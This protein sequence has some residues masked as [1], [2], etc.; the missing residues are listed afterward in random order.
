MRIYLSDKVFSGE[1]AFVYVKYETTS[2]GRALSWLDINQ[3]DSKV[4]PYMNSEC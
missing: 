1:K 3:T 2:E 4:L